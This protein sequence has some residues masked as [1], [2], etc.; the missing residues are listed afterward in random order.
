MDYQLRPEKVK[1]KAIDLAYAARVVV[2]QLSLKDRTPEALMAAEL[3][4]KALTAAIPDSTANY[5]GKGIQGL[6]PEKV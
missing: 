4:E 2:Q 5:E 1:E 3:I 6:S